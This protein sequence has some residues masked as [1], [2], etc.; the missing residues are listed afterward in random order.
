MR[1]S[2]QKG[3]YLIVSFNKSN[4]LLLFLCL[5][6][7]YHLEVLPSESKTGTLIAT[8][9]TGQKGER[10][11]RIRFWLKSENHELNMYPK[12]SNFVDD[13]ESMSRT[14]VI[15]NLPTG[16]YTLQFLIPNKDAFFE[17][18]TPREFTI[19]EDETTKINQ[20]IKSSRSPAAK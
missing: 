6:F 11:D 8:Y 19:Q 18:I 14:V 2:I 15:E 1:H 16:K 10:L 7:F 5:S 17:E 9:Q 3:K 12:G 4:F 20:K 13:Q